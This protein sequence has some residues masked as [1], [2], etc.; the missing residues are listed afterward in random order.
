MKHFNLLKFTP[1]PILLLG[2]LLAGCSSKDESATPADPETQ[3]R[4]EAMK[5]EVQEY[6]QTKVS[7]PPE[8][9]EDLEA[10]RVTQ[11]E[12]DKRIA[13][14]EF[15][16]FFNFKTPAD[17]P[18]GLN[19]KD[20]S[21]LPEIG[22][23]KAVKGGTSYSSIQDF[24]R[25]LRTIGPDANGSFRTYLLDYNA[26]QIARQHPNSTELGEDGPLFFAELA[27]EWA[28]DKENQ[29]V[30]VKLDPSARWSDGKA[31]TADDFL[32]MFFFMQSSYIKAPWYNNFYNRSYR[33]IT[34]YDDQTFSIQ[35]SIAKP[36]FA[37]YA[38]GLSPRPE[39]F[40]GELGDD[41]PERYQWRFEPTTGAYVIEEGD[42]RKG[43]SIVFT[44]QKDWWAQDKRNIRYRYNYDKRRLQV[45][46]DV[47][48]AFEMFK[49]GELDAASLSLPKYW[50]D[51][52]PDDDKL[53][54]GGYIKK[55][56]F[57]NQRP[58]PPYGMWINTAKPLLNDRNIRIGI[59]HA[60]NWELVIDK[61]FRGDYERLN[62]TAVGY[63]EFTNP[64]I[65]ARPFSIEKALESFAKAGFDKRGS[66]GILEN[67]KGEK[68]SFSLTTGYQTF[69]EPLTIIKEEAAKAGL[70]LRLQVLDSTAGYKRAIEKQHDIHFMAW[71]YGAEMY[72]RYWE[73]FH[74]LNAY[75]PDGSIKVQTNNLNSMAVP[76]LDAMIEKYR[77]SSDTGEM[78]KLAH[79]MEQLIHDEAVFVPA[80]YIPFY[81]AGYWSWREYPEDFNV[82]TS[83]SPSEFSL[84]WMDPKKKRE[85]LDALKK[86]KTFE[87]S[88][89]VYDQYKSAD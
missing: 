35:V 73:T 19:W 27:E 25:T 15:P 26:L 7:L 60:S 77:N 21:D 78:I 59:Q 32:F 65:K 54:E 72:P 1:L 47:E 36:D 24:P 16:K 74:S 39:H 58:R 13:A 23:P 86:G 2:G 64:D 18:D 61:Y 69:Q 80:F 37:T 50:Y 6:Y 31:V 42:V 85:I 4:I 51:K 79:Q 57:Y 89:K 83:D 10:G 84:S 8:L 48:K 75:N 46:R 29:T 45:V 38:L 63:G 22:S 49:K 55:A 9:F 68:L 71:G 52:L 14:G 53:V 28:V 82:M 66:D 34:K 70:D 20:G 81:R 43:E 56:V 17:L 3:A 76:E 30:Y 67:S 87:K 41:F 40:Y 33:G 62:H 88:V 44:R 11:E 5:A 12:V